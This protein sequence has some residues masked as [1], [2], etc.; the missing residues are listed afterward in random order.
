MGF[1]TSA[2]GMNSGY[3]A[4]PQQAGNPYGQS[5][6][7]NEVNNQNEIYANQQG[8]GQQLQNMIQGGGPNP[9]QTQYQQNVNQNNQMAQGLLSSQRGLNPALAAKM[10]SNLSS[11]ANQ[12]AAMQSS[13]LQQQQQLGAL[14]GYGNLL[15]QQQQGNLGQQGLFTGANSAAMNTNAN[16]AAANQQQQ[17]KL[18]GGILSGISTIASGGGAAAAAMNQGGM[19]SSPKSEAGQFLANSMSKGGKVNGA[20]KVSG[21]SLKNDT[22][23]AMLSPGEIVIPRTIAKSANAPDHAK[24]FVEAI[25]ARDNI[26]KG[27]K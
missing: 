25:L 1:L 15:G 23:P 22:V 12:Q 17:G 5:V 26:K 13:L 9:A 14:Q 20:A 21:D 10:G 19:V 7:Q 27:K 16:V 4:T 6:L 8:L 24:Q 2:L 3:Q 11:N 18:V